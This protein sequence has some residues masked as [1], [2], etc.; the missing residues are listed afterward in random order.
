MLL[1]TSELKEIQLVCDRAIVIFGGE[2]V[3][4]LDAA[5]ADEASLLRAAHNLPPEGAPATGVA[6]RPGARHERHD[7]HARRPARPAARD[8]GGHGPAQRLDLG[9]LAF[10]AALLVFTKIIQPS[11]GALGI[12]NLAV[13]VLPLAMAAV[14]QAIV[15]IAGGIDLS[16]AS[17]MALTASCRPS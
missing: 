9:L 17:M 1:Y 16:I 12:Q 7:R 3:A 13:S 2:V 8:A 5:T 14:A 11:Y 10:L 15:V 6:A 4:E